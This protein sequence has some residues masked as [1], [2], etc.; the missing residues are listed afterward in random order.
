[1]RTFAPDK[2][3]PENTLTSLIPNSDFLKQNSKLN[4]LQRRWRVRGDGVVIR[5][6]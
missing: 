1:M 4:F 2:N 5:E 3:E 6:T